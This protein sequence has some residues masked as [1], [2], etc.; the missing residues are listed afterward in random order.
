MLEHLSMGEHSRA[1]H[2]CKPGGPYRHLKMCSPGYMRSARVRALCVNI[3]I[4][5]QVRSTPTQVCIVTPSLEHDTSDPGAGPKSTGLGPVPP[6]SDWSK[7]QLVEPLFETED[8]VWMNQGACRV[9]DGIDLS[10]FFPTR[11]ERNDEAVAI[12]NRCPVTKECLDYALVNNIIYGVWGGVSERKRRYMR[13][14]LRRRGHFNT[15]R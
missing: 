4:A 11:G 8:R 15:P 3:D 14:E 7:L 10:V 12:C 5:Q 1:W 2:A 6:L 9:E 13:A